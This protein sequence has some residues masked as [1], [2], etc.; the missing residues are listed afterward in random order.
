MQSVD[1]ARRPAPRAAVTTLGTACLLVGLLCGFTVVVPFSETA[2]RAL[3]A[4]LAAVALALG[5]V[6]LR[7][8]PR[9]TVLAMH[10][11]LVLA[12]G[13]M[14]L[15][16]LRSTTPVG[17]VVT[18]AGFFW[19]A[20]FAAVFLTRTPFLAYL[21]GI[22]G[23]LALGL[24]QAG[25]PSPVQTWVF[26]LGT[27]AGTSWVLHRKV[28]SLR[29]I[30]AQD[31]LTGA[32][33]RRSLLD[34][35][36]REL[37]WSRRTGRPV[38]L[39]LLDLDDFKIINDTQG[40]AAG[41]EVLVGL[42]AAWRTELRA[43]DVL[44]RWGGDEFAVLLPATGEEEARRVVARLAGADQRCSWSAGVA[45]GAADS[46]D[47]WISRADDALYRAKRA[48]AGSVVGE[49][50][51]GEEVETEALGQLGGREAPSDAV[52]RGVQ[53]R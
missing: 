50:P 3:G 14:T 21:V 4:V 43:G 10:A 17:A 52:A 19:L 45:A 23:G 8:A 5:A 47:E 25:S 20:V 49:R 37:A 38:S 34:A 44:G 41:D 24:A 1:A 13:L 33:T 35:A 7:L 16:V 12:L 30:A 51:R 53:R 27:M 29:A 28:T 42:T 36:E 32:A 31:A 18:A 40:H 48:R 2:P 9:V 11:V 6:L 22:G 15:A 26:Y 39:V 46:L